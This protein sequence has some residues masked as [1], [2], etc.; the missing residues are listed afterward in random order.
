MVHF[1]FFDLRFLFG[2]QQIEEVCNT[3]H[4]QY[5]GN[6]APK[7]LVA[8]TFILSIATLVDV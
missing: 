6:V 4:G 8:P 1:C 3:F 5:S 7:H 2:L